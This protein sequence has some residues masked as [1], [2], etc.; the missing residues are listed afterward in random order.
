MA[1]SSELEWE[2]LL[3][4]VTK[5]INLFEGAGSESTPEDNAWFEA[6]KNSS[7][8]SKLSADKLAGMIMKLEEYPVKTGDVV[9]R[10]NDAGDYY[11]IVKSGK[12]TV[13]RKTGPGEVEI[14]ASLGEKA[15]FGEDALVS[16]ARRNASIVAD[17]DGVLMR[18]SKDNFDQ[19]LKSALVNYVDLKETKEKVKQGAKVLD[20]RPNSP[21]R[22]GGIKDAMDMPVNQLR[23][24]LSELDKKTQYIIYCQTGNQSEAAAFLLSQR[25]FDV[26]VLKGGLQGIKA[27]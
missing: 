21:D 25:G 7:T 14:L 9:I 19:I 6:I 4:E 27:G 8:F 26:A 18:L 3:D 11:Y 15:A 20:V 13:S 16:G 22:K 2:K 17:S 10:Q 12:F 5:T 23:D 24:R 1:D